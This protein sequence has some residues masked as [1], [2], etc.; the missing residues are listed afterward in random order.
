MAEGCRPARL[1]VEEG[2]R[3]PTYRN[4]AACLCGY[5]PPSALPTAHTAS[6]PR[7]R[8]PALPA[9]PGLA[10]GT[11]SGAHLAE[12]ALG[13][14]GPRKPRLWIEIAV[15]VAALP[16]WRLGA[17]VAVRVAS[18]WHVAPVTPSKLPVVLSSPSELPGVQP[19]D[20]GVH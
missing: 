12:A 6:R 20:P 19:Q 14:A 5:P 18:S 8:L 4:R 15:S 16:P 11:H 9:L 17:A 10:R 13:G 1:E 7:H 2:A 3:S